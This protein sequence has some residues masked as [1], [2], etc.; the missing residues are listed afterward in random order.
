MTASAMLAAGSKGFPTP[1]N[2]QTVR[3]SCWDWLPGLCWTSPELLHMHWLW[4]A[5]EGGWGGRRKTGSPF[6][7]CPS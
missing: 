5:E 1:T 3:E 2:T 4:V 7:P 6:L